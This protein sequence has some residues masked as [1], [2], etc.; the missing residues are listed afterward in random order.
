M[1][2]TESGIILRYKYMESNVPTVSGDATNPMSAKEPIVVSGIDTSTQTVFGVPRRVI[3]FGFGL[4]LMLVI[5]ALLYSVYTKSPRTIDLSAQPSPVSSSSTSQPVSREPA[6]V[7]PVTSDTVVDSLVSEA[8][9]ES[10]DVTQYDSDEVA[11][12]EDGSNN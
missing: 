11:D 3:G 9:A 5:L 10:A 6:V 4:F 8:V 12:I 2:Y 7:A 1:S